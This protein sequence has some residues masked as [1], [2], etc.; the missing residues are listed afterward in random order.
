MVRFYVVSSQYIHSPYNFAV[1]FIVSFSKRVFVYGKDHVSE[2]SGA[3]ITVNS[4]YGR[5][6][7]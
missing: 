4:E 2:E 3:V 1:H 7:F 6:K 5:R